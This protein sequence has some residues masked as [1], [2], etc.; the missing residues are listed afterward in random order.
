MYTQ[1]ILLL[2]FE[3]V[4]VGVFFVIYNKPKYCINMLDIW[5]HTVLLQN[6][7]MGQKVAKGK[8]IKETFNFS[9]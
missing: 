5:I 1:S 8:I 9:T 7:T 2:I 4:L 3:D 6:S